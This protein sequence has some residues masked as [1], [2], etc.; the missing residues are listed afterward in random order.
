M[1]AHDGSRQP[2]GDIVLLDTTMPFLGDY[3]DP[4][5]SVKMLDRF[6]ARSS[7]LNALTAQLSNLSGI[8][9]DV[10]CGH[11]PYESLLLNPPSGVQQYIGLDIP[12]NVYS[13]PDVYWDG[14]TMPFRQSSIDCAIATE[15]LEHVPH[16]EVAMTEICRVL[17]PGGLFFF[18]VPFLWPLHDVPNDEYRYTPFALQRHL[19][20]AGF[21]QI[22]LR[23]LGGWNASLAQM[24]ALWVRRKPMTS[25]KRAFL[26]RL[27]LPIVR[28]L[29]RHD[30]PP[31][32]FSEGTM[33]TGLSGAARKRA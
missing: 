11:K 14:M 18:T 8:L 15:V 26:S 6:A 20:E 32:T 25:R 10:G 5:C 23:A 17:K 22:S 4:P 29:L 9:V 31:T 12:G 13:P 33:V 16:P 1:S 21:G 2:G 27:V 7:I 24:I 19:T 3:L 28:Y 30:V